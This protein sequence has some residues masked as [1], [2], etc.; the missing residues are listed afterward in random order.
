M[1]ILSEWFGKGRCG[2]C[3]APSVAILTVLGEARRDT[4]PNELSAIAHSM[5]LEVVASTAAGVSIP[6]CAACARGE[7]CAWGTNQARQD[8][9]KERTFLQNLRRCFTRLGRSRKER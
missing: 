1:R 7:L 2:R 6:V 3:G 9:A 4:G 8:G 5:G